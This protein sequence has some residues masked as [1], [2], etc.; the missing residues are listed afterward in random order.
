MEVVPFGWEATSRQLSALGARPSMRRQSDGKPFL[1]DGGHY[2]LDCSFD[3]SVEAATLAKSLD[4]V[5]GLVE[6]GL[7][8]GFTSEVHVASAAG[9]RVLRL[10][11][12]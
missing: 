1:S 4:H 12:S 10:S 5:V 6:H 11:S 9:V 2:I 8:I 7:F 3:P